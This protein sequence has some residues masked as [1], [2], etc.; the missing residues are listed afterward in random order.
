MAPELVQEQPYNHSVDIWSYGI[1]LYELFAGQPPF[2]T[3]NLYSLIKMIVKNPVKYPDKMSSEFK[4]FLKGLLVKEPNKRMRWPEIMEHPFLKCTT[5]DK[6]EEKRVRVKYNNWLRQVAQWNKDFSEFKSS[7]IDFFT[8][9]VY[10]YDENGFTGYGPNRSTLR[11][12]T[13]KTKRKSKSSE[14]ESL[15]QAEKELTKIVEGK[16]NSI[17]SYLDALG[18]FFDRFK[19]KSTHASGDK[20]NRLFSIV[21]ELLKKF[22]DLFES[23]SKSLS[24]IQTSIRKIIENFK[25]KE[26][27]KLFGWLIWLKISQIKKIDSGFVKSLVKIRGGKEKL[28]LKES[29]MFLEI[30][31][32]IY[33]KMQKNFTESQNMITDIVELKLIDFAFSKNSKV[34]TDEVLRSKKG[35]QIKISFKF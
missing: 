27:L 22:P 16:S 8:S 34:I 14:I 29:L 33:E 26:Y 10:N 1:I 11:K 7:K 32:E 24:Q 17:R 35:I 20:I 12:K 28:N 31:K 2:Y 3:N 25:L 23:N 19:D 9:E 15:E 21:S 13:K 6:E 18:N 30:M 5:A 4:S